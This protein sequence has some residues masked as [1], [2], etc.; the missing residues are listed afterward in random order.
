VVAII[1][2]VTAGVALGIV[3]YIA[4]RRFAPAEE[5]ALASTFGARWDAY[6]GTV[7]LR[8]V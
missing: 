5:R 8:S 6:A 1:A 2:L 4:T 3:M 7:L